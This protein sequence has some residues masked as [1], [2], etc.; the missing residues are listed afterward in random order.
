MLRAIMFNYQHQSNMARLRINP[1]ASNIMDAMVSF[2]TTNGLQCSPQEVKAFLGAY[3]LEYFLGFLRTVM[4]LEL[5][6][7]TFNYATVGKVCLQLLSDVHYVIRDEFK[8]EGNSTY[9]LMEAYLVPSILLTA[10]ETALRAAKKDTDTSLV[11][12]GRMRRV[13]EVFLN[14]KKDWGNEY[15][16]DLD[17]WW[18]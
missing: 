1:Y 13:A 17:Q 5:G 15:L 9:V 3:S 16:C 11:V 14:Y 6:C 7:C 12:S 4:Q 8:K 2:Q 18:R 10:E